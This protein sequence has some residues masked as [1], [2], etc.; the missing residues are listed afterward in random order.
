M[1]SEFIQRQKN[2]FFRDITS[3]GS[4][5]FYIIFMFF[6]LILNDY[7][8]LKILLLGF[9]AMYFAVIIIRLLYF[10][11][12]PIKYNY[13]NAIEKLDASSFPSLHAARTAFLSGFFIKYFSSHLASALLAVLALIVLYSRIHLKKHDWKDVLAG[14]VLGIAAYFAVNYIL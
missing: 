2:D 7:S 6:F 11:N 14:V 8:S 9:I 3:F 1:P 4:L 10:K 13:N 12:R 5:W